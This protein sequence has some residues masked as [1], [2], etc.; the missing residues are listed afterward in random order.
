[1]IGV[2]GEMLTDNVNLFVDVGLAGGC[3]LLCVK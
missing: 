1:M 2:E 3:R